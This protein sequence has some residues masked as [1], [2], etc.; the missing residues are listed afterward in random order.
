MPDLL[1]GGR[2]VSEMTF[3]SVTESNVII[4][5]LGAPLDLAPTRDDP[6]LGADPLR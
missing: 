2:V 3:S 5:L 1:A 4:G 6:K